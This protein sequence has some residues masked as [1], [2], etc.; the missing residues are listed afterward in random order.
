LH[1]S[2]AEF[3]E[4]VQEYKYP[5]AADLSHSEPDD[6]AGA[7]TGPTPAF[8]G[9][10]APDMETCDQCRKT[11]MF[12]AADG[13]F[14][15]EDGS[16][17]WSKDGRIIHEDRL[18]AIVDAERLRLAES[19]VRTPAEQ[20]FA[21]ESRRLAELHPVPLVQNGPADQDEAARRLLEKIKRERVDPEIAKDRSDNGINRKTL[22]ADTDSF[23]AIAARGTDGQPRD[24]GGLLERRT[25]RSMG[26]KLRRWL[27]GYTVRELEELDR[28]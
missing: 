18:Q 15:H 13:S 2:A 26:R 24:A 11:V 28:R 27:D 25:W 6:S 14:T 20:E 1:R 10:V 22:E 3:A 23:L 16:P 12:D 19:P 9:R 17:A 4:D 7:G 21:G 5:I 8:F